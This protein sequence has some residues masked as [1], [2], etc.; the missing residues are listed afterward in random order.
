MP[1]VGGNRVEIL[2][3]GGP[4][5]R[6]LI[7]AIAS[8]EHY[9]FLETYIVAADRTGWRVADALAERARAG[10]EIAFVFD[11]YGSMGL[12]DRYTDFLAEH[13]V[14]LLRFHPLS[15]SKGIWP[16]SKR[17]HRKV[18]VVDGRVGIVGGMNISDDYA[19]VD[20]GGKGWRDTAVRVEGP[21]VSELERMFRALWSREGRTPLAATRRRPPD[22]PGGTEVRFL[23]STALGDRNF[24]R[25]AYLAAFLG[26]ER[27]IRIA[28]AYFIPDRVVR[29][30]LVRAARRGIRVEVIVGGATDVK[31]AL[32]ATRAYYSRFLKH[33]IRIYE[34]TESVLH[35]KTAVVDG[36]WTTIGS[37]NLDYLSMRNLEVN[38]G[39]FDARVGA[40]MED[41][42]EV[43]RAKSRP[44][45]RALWK[46]RPFLMRIFEW[47]YF[48]LA[49]R[50]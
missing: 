44:V 3:D 43:D 20:D 1:F 17:N 45:E 27:S 18:L 26:A 22:F 47:F 7:E 21:A 31:A 40:A 25:R 28:N 30:A 50:Y 16:W 46:E 9:V 49:R 32:Y 2:V 4:Y 39:F 36:E 41:Q 14:K 23:G 24:I 42:F 35:A 6:S 8:A 29:R 37:S 33:G 34:W 13:G 10:V 15:F 19:A 12:D 48:L 38:A 5:Y 11:G